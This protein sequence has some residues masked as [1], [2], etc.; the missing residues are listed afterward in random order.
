M[1]HLPRL[2]DL[3][4]AWLLLAMCASPRANH[5]LRAVSPFDI[6]GFAQAHDDARGCPRKPCS[7]RLGATVCTSHPFR[8]K[9]CGPFL[10]ESR[11][12]PLPLLLPALR[13]TTTD[14]VIG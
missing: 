6:A 4:C 12:R 9:R 11:A 14:A 10:G 2:P 8:L 7:L 5:A 13:Q 3:Q 1:S